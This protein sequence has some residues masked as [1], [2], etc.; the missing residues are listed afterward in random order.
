MGRRWVWPSFDQRPT[1]HRQ[2]SLTRRPGHQLYDK[3]IQRIKD[4]ESAHGRDESDADMLAAGLEIRLCPKCNTRIEKNEGCVR[5]RHAVPLSPARVGPASH[6]PPP[7]PSRR[8]HVE[9]CRLYDPTLVRWFV[10]RSS[11]SRFAR[12]AAALLTSGYFE[13]RHACDPLV[14]AELDGLLHMWQQVR[15]EC[16]G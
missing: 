10:A 11:P 14:A 13:L 2:S 16:G 6:S 4:A 1:R 9:A 8:I 7:P 12:L 5:L 3:L 15:L